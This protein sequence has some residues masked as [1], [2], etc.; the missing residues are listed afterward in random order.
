MLRYYLKQALGSLW[1][2]R[3]YSCLCMLG[4]ALAFAIVSLIYAHVRDELSFNTWIPGHEQVY[5]VTV[6]GRVNG[7]TPSLPSDVGLWM[8]EDIPEA[9]VVTRMLLGGGTISVGDNDIN[10]GI[11]WADSNVFDVLPFPVVAGRAENALSEPGATVLTRSFARALFG[12]AD[13][14][15]KTMQLNF[16]NDLTVTAVIE[17][18][19]PNSTLNYRVLTAAHAVFSPLYQQDRTPIQQFGSK[20]WSTATFMKLRA[21]SSLEAVTQ[22]LADMQNRRTPINGGNGTVADG[23]PLRPVALADLHLAEAVEGEV[24]L[25]YN[26]IAVFSAVGLLILLAGTINFVNIQ[27]AIGLR[28]THAVAIRKSCGA[29]R[30]QVFGQYMSESILLVLASAALG[31]ILA[32]LLLPALNAYLGKRLTLDYLDNPG[33]LV[34]IVACFVAVALLS[35]LYPSILAANVRPSLALNDRRAGGAGITALVRQ[36]L[37]V[38]QFAIMTGLLVAT[39]VIYQQFN[40][41]LREALRNY[42]D[43]VLLLYIPCQRAFVDSVAQ[44]PGVLGASCSQGLPQQGM[45]VMSGIR[46]GETGIGVRNGMVAAGFTELYDM[47]LLAGRYISDD[48]AQ[49]RAPADNNWENRAESIL[50]N[51]R[52]VLALGF[53]SPEDAVG[54]LVLFNHIFRQPAEFTGFHRAEIVG[55]LEDFQMGT[56]EA[57]IEP[58]ALFTNPNLLNVVHIKISGQ[59]LQETIDAIE[60]QFDAIGTLGNFAPAFY[61]QR[62]QALYLGLQRQAQLFAVLSGIAI[63]I[64]LLGLLG[65]ACHAAVTRTREAGIRKCLGST[66]WSLTRLFLWQFARP[67]IVANLVGWIGAWYFMSNWLEGFARRIDLQWWVFLEA[68]VVTLGLALLTVF[69]YVWRLAG[70]QPA[71]ALRYE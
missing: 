22:G 66:R 4:L 12:A 56:V 18:P 43:P 23:Y 14:I 59:S 5:Q 57:P 53:A 21:G 38:L 48:L 70:N 47:P 45:P 15:G 64:S 55:V 29:N 19:P 6:A 16:Q 50:L 63:F 39:A 34:G 40:F 27:V 68:L 3:L 30:V 61:E 52:A 37:V 28:N 71:L 1:R 9:E 8:A 7:L 17:D 46:R 33:L 26:S 31:M 24:V 65:L 62:V 67:V 42:D 10:V 60:Q 11:Y 44:L 2:K 32:E 58:A 13:P 35:G 25:N 69:S 49:D 54:E 36:G 41:G 20:V 51:E